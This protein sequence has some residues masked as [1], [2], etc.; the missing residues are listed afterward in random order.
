[1]RF[2]HSFKSIN[3]EFKALVDNVVYYIKR[4]RKFTSAISYLDKYSYILDNIVPV[5]TSDKYQNK[6]WQ[7][8]FQGKENMP[9]IVQ[10]CTQSVSKYHKDRVIFLDDNNIKDYIEL[11]E[12]IL[13]KYKKGIIP[14]ANFSDILRLSLLAKYGGC[15]VDSTIYLTGEIPQDILSADFFSFQSIY[16][17]L[18]KNIHNLDDYK[19]Y[20]NYLNKIINFESPYFI[21]AKA[22]NEIINGV[23]SLFLE[24][25]KYENSVKDYL[26]I[27][28]FFVL[29]LL[30][31]EKYKNMF[32]NMPTY[33]IEN[34]LI[35][36]RAQF[37]RFDENLFNQI[38]TKSSV[39]KM[40]HKNLKR[41]PYK[42]SLLQ[43]IL[44][45]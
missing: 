12:Y 40:S 30:H 7:C 38:K 4:K 45:E 10:K 27:D 20:N 11:P 33:Y 35:M 1:M 31:N 18:L 17:P 19:M 23:L 44:N 3:Y 9:P 5:E 32:L 21:E 29:T 36:P 41:S 39:H 43:H 6:I 28:K 34:V 24:Y 8:W 25:W 22:G 16:T 14:H 13:D 42:D 26:M 15:W 2:F 37:E